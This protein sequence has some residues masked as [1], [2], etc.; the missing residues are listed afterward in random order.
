MAKNEM[1]RVRGKLDLQIRKD[2]EDYDIETITE[3]AV[4]SAIINDDDFIE[5]QTAYL[6]AQK[7]LQT[8][9]NV[10]NHCRSALK[11]IEARKPSLEHLVILLKMNYFSAPLEERNLKHE[12]RTK[13]RKESAKSKVRNHKKRK[14]TT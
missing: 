12:V 4:K 1:D 5:A 14:R 8:Q 13:M 11:K 7:D 9:K 2:P 10:L 3:A 6:D